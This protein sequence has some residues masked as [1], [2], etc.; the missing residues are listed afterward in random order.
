MINRRIRNFE[1]KELIA[2]G[3]MA[4][5]YKAN[6]VTL[7]RIV[8]VKILHGHLAQD[9]DFIIRFEREAKAAANLQH[10]NIV[11]IIDFGQEEEV[12]F[13][14]MEYVDGKSLKDI[15]NQ[16]KFIPQEIALGIILEIG[17]GLNYAHQKGIVHR[18]IK[19]ANILIG[20]DGIVKIADFGLAQAQDLTTITVTG[21]IVGT[22]AYMSPE[23]AAGKKVDNR[24]D[25]FS[26]GVV[27]YEM[28]IG[29]KPFKGENYSSVIHEILTINPIK[30]F[31]ANPLI[32]KELSTVIEKMLEKDPDKRY[33]N[34]EEVSEDIIIQM[35]RTRTEINRKDIGDFISKPEE[36]L[37]NLMEKRKERHFERGIYFMNSGYEKIDDAIA[38][39]E[40]VLLLD[41]NDARAKNYLET[42]KTKRAKIPLQKKIKEKKPAKKSPIFIGMLAGLIA[43]AIIIYFILNSFFRVTSSKELTGMA[44]VNTMPP[45]AEIFFDNDST[46]MITPATLKGL[47]IGEHQLAL[48]K[49]GYKPFVQKIEI[50]GNDTLK[51]DITLLTEIAKEDTVTLIKPPVPKRQLPPIQGMGYLKVK[52]NPWA[53][54]YI[55]G[56]YVET[57][58]IARSLPVSSGVHSVRLENPNYKVWQRNLRFNPGDTLNLN[59]RLELLEGALKLIVRPWADVYIDGKFYET[60]PIAQ[61]IKLSAGEHRLKL[62]NPLYK[63]YEEVIVIKPNQVLKKSVELEKK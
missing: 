26:L 33:Q 42:L 35:K 60:T 25:I 4:A 61:P 62:I 50:K 1:I 58:P 55:D 2:T 15:L 19:P 38:E 53:K 44:V 52:V 21:A 23:Q 51:L 54:I 3:G 27:F 22:P 20:Y 31:E 30:A 49:N 17:K 34:I 48:K 10:E 36:K 46:G 37:K 32:A 7:D 39:F 41:P 11:N 43:I 45:G 14:A 16:V 24:S 8:A 57:T 5:I 63:P 59:V 6:Q 13:I 9:K 28:L 40:K 29:V 18:D 12:Y 47:T 56:Q